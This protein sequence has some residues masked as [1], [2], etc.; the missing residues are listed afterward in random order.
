M[1]LLDID[2]FKLLNDTHGHAAGDDVLVSLASIMNDSAR[3]SDLIARYGGEEFVILMPNTDLAGA[4]HLA[5]KIRMTVESTRLIVGDNMKPINI[6]ISLGVA[7]YGGNRREFFAEA[8][9]A[10]YAAEGRGQE[11]RD[12]RGQR[13]AWSA[14]RGLEGRRRLSLREPA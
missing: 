5:E 6:T 8:D 1:I 4:V 3:E 10:L 11:L 2:D 14:G 13:R 7:L 12:H 9:R